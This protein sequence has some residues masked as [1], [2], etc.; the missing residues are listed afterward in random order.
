M[1]NTLSC[2]FLTKRGYWGHIL[3]TELHQKAE[4]TATSVT[5]ASF[6]EHEKDLAKA[7]THGAIFA[8][9]GVKHFLFNNMFKSADLSIKLAKIEEW[10]KIRMIN[11]L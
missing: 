9:T 11:W 4:V 1:A 5:V 7:S 2:N 10:N 6:L 8:L 3:L